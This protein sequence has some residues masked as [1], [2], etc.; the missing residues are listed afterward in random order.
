M[1]LHVS[2]GRH[3]V[4]R[5]S[6]RRR[7]HWGSTCEG[8][9]HD[10]VVAA[11]IDRNGRSAGGGRAGHGD[12]AAPVD[13]ASRAE[14]AHAV[15]KVDRIDEVTWMVWAERMPMDLAP[16]AQDWQTTVPGVKH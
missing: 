8:G 14:G 16:L 10:H 4:G 2:H 13:A 12:V 3:L 9:G 6:L 7:G 1:R 15:D 5:Q 11:G